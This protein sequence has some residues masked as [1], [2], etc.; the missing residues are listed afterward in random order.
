[1]SL[2]NKPR[3][4]FSHPRIIYSSIDKY[5][6]RLITSI[7]ISICASGVLLFSVSPKTPIAHLS[8]TLSYG[9]WRI[10]SDSY[11]FKAIRRLVSSRIFCPA[12]LNGLMMIFGM[13]GAIM[14]QT[15][16][17]YVFN[18]FGWRTTILDI[19]LFGFI[20]A[21]TYWTIVR[22]RETLLSF[23]VNPSKVNIP[24]KEGLKTLFKNPQNYLLVLY[25]GLAWTTIT[26]FAGFW[27][28]PFL[29]N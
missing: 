11:R 21:L 3:P 16:F 17:N 28:T 9:N 5:G 14:G 12:L 19:S 23:K 20:L 6:T 4:F 10:C 8:W 13:T 2:E 29:K 1:M 22:D 24:Y 25:R 7:G 27:E 18:I 15:P 26:V